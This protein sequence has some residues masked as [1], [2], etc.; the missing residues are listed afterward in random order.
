MGEVWVRFTSPKT[1]Y[2]IAVVALKLL[3]A[4]Y[5]RHKDRLRRFQQEAQAASALKSSKHPDYL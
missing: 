2:S 5:I 4:D 1:I 3:P